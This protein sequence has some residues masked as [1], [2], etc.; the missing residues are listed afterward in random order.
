M[1]GE[2]LVLTDSTHCVNKTVLCLGVN[3][4]GLIREDVLSSLD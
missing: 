1:Y 2:S 4:A 3:D